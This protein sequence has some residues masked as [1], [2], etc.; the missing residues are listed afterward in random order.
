ML[1]YFKKGKYWSFIFKFDS[2]WLFVA[3]EMQKKKKKKVC[4][5]YGEGVVTDRTCPKW[6]ANFLGSTDILS[7]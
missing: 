3:T 2:L 1:Y 7:K 4:A 6:F 5:V